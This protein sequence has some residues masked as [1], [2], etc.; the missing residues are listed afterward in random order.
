MSTLSTLNMDARHVAVIGGSAGIGLETARLLAGQG[1]R[2]TIG[3]RDR[4]RLDTAVKEMGDQA[5]AVAVD[6]EQAGS[7]REFFAQAGPITDLVVTVTRKG[8]TGPAQDLADAD[9]PGAF[10]GK[11]IAHL[12]AVALA[13]PTLAADGSVTLVTAGSAQSALP[14]TVELAAVNGALESAVPPLAA[15]LAPRRVNAVSPGVIETGWWDVV[16]ED[17]RRETFH[18]FAQRALVRRNGQPAD[19]A[20]AII[21]LV[22]NGFITGAVLP[23]DG[24]LRLT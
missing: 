12:R 13:L 3:A 17:A 4:D 21:A 1:A 8:G 24:G 11:T 15:E 16:P 7:L 5:R 18:A 2:V 9:L 23:C 6:A 14:G 22:G 10:A 20:Q 19:V